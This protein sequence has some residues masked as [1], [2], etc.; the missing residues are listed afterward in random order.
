M[1]DPEEFGRAIGEAIRK[2][3]AQLRTEVVQNEKAQEALMAELEARI[4][5]LESKA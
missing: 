4:A 1:V 3:V 2:A 5:R